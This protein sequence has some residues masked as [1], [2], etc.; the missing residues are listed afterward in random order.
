MKTADAYNRLTLLAN[1]AG[2]LPV[3]ST[4]MQDAIVRAGDIGWD[5]QGRRLVLL[6]SRYRW[7]TAEKT[8]VR[9]ALRI[10]TV[11]NV[12]RRNWPHD[13]D[14]ALAMLAITAE[15]DRI[16]IAFAGNA[17]VRAD[18]ECLDVLLE[19]ISPPWEVQRLPS[20]G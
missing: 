17:S 9:T 15:G 2:D 14:A 7:E 10:E 16:T 4:L 11:R 6:A 8:R 3:L 20:H 13:A 5:R 18:I 1:D 12:Q 19:D